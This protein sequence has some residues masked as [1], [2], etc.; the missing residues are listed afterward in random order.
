[1]QIF[2]KWPVVGIDTFAIGA[3]KRPAHALGAEFAIPDDLNI[4]AVIFICTETFMVDI[5]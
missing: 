5:F 1:M 3:I 4:V 2:L